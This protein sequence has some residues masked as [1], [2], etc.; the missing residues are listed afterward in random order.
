MGRNARPVGIL[1]ILSLPLALA[2]NL[3]SNFVADAVPPA[4]TP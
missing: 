4:W 1:A 3:L 2:A